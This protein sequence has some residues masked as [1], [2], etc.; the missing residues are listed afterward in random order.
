[1]PPVPSGGL[2]QVRLKVL[3]ESE[4]GEGGARAWWERAATRLEQVGE[5]G[6]AATTNPLA[7]TIGMLAARARWK[8]CCSCQW[9]GVAPSSRVS[10]Q[11]AVEGASR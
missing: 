10:A 2:K 5:C 11:R 4:R 9:P 1:M 3:Q 6:A 8:R 7:A